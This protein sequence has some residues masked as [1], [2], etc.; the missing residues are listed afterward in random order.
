[1]YGD[2]TRKMERI[3]F[4]SLPNYDKNKYK[5]KEQNPLS[6]AFT[7]MI[8]IMRKDMDNISDET[9]KHMENVLRIG[10]VAMV[11]TSK[12]EGEELCIHPAINVE[13]G[14]EAKHVGDMMIDLL[15]YSDDP[16]RFDIGVDEEG[17]L[18]TEF[19]VDSN[20][21]MKVELTVNEDLPITHDE[22]DNLDVEE[23]IFDDRSPGKGLTTWEMLSV[24]LC[25]CCTIMYYIN[26]T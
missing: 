22:S 14:Q 5:M 2:D 21:E 11:A 23:Y 7:T 8:N 6:K 15:M 19:G 18:C 13:D 10:A 26:L 25:L 20:Q 12:S 16:I 3:H 9:K 17:I 24:G 4:S 1:M